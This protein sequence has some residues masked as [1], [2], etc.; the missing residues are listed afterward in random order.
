MAL[1]LDYRS[2]IAVALVVALMLAFAGRCGFGERWPKSRLIAYLGQISYSV[3]LI[4]F[5]ICLIINGLF[6]RFASRD[7]WVNLAGM[8]IAWLAS[9]AGRRTFLPLGR[10]SGAAGVL[11]DCVQASGSPRRFQPACRAQ[12]KVAQDAVSARPFEGQ[13]ALENACLLRPASRSG[14]RP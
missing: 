5:P 9:I 10:K 8:I 6:A 4:H 3:F 2:R 7:P 13:Q 14:R 12:R 1:L 11:A